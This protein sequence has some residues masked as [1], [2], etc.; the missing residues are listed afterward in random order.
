MKKI[1][2]SAFFVIFCVILVSCGTS[3]ETSHGRPT[4][5][6]GRLAAASTYSIAVT[7]GR[8]QVELS[9]SWEG[10]CAT[11]TITS[12]AELAGVSVVSDASGC[13]ITA[14][15]ATV[16]LSPEAASWVTEMHSA[17]RKDLTGADVTSSIENGVSVYSYRDGDFDVKVA[18]GEDGT[19]SEITL[20]RDGVT[21]KVTLH[22]ENDS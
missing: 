22:V 19:P 8:R 10:K 18:L 9:V 11:A 12:P 21:R 3:F 17:A 7:D 6:D 14:K 5:P 13:R 4:K 15:G 20:S 16:A 2:F 1:V